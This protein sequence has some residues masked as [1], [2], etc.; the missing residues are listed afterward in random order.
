MMYATEI[1]RVAWYIHAKS[2]DDRFRH[3]SNIKGI[4]STVSEVTALVLE[5]R[6][7]YAIEMTLV[8]GM[9]YTYRVTLR[10]VQ[11]FKRYE[12]FVSKF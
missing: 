3:S 6:G 4:A 5:T 7:M 8:A 10:L 1:A 9:M 11:A 2:H 12:C